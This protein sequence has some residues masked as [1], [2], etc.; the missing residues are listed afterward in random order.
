MVLSGCSAVCVCEVC[1]GVYVERSGNISSPYYPDPYPN[2]KQCVY[3][4]RQ[5]EGSTITL[6]FLRFSLEASYPHG[7]NSTCR[8]DYL[9]VCHSPA[10]RA[11]VNV[12]RLPSHR[13]NSAIASLRG[14]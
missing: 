4:I 9:E 5:P 6:T 11:K 2:D 12:K 14:C 13:V 10:K 3:V 7:P 1:G 8:H